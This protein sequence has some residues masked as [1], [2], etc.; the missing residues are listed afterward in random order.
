DQHCRCCMGQYIRFRQDVRIQSSLQHLG[1]PLLASGHVPSSVK[2]S[3][4]TST[5]TTPVMRTRLRNS[6]LLGR[7]IFFLHENK[8]TPD[9]MAYM[10]TRSTIVGLLFVASCG[11]SKH[12]PEPD[13]FEEALPAQMP[14]LVKLSGSVLA[15]PKIQPIFFTGDSAVQTQI[16]DFAQQLA[17]SP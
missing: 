17:G 15:T 2:A 14:Q 1:E 5:A 8:P 6:E 9:A 7:G 3:S 11:T 4:I 10:I 13:A 16:E 12:T